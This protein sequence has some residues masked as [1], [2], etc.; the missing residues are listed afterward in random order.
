[1]LGVDLGVKYPAYMCLSDDTYKREHIGS[2]NDFLKVRTQMQNRR[3][4]LSKALSLI[5][6]EKVEIKNTSI[7]KIK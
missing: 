3:R 6:E 7:K 5:T 2:I 1:M 4:E